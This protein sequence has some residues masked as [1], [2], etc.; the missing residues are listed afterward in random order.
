MN[1]DAPDISTAR[2]NLACLEALSLPDQGL[3]L[4]KRLTLRFPWGK[5][6]TLDSLRPFPFSLYDPDPNELVPGLP[7]NECQRAI[8]ILLDKPWDEIMRKGYVTKASRQP[9]WYQLRYVISAEGWAVANSLEFR[10]EITAKDWTIEL[11]DD[12]RDT[13]W[14]RNFMRQAD[15]YRK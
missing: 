3:F 13:E 11:D 5:I 6:F 8:Q 9:Y 2:S 14:Y 1:S 10:N 12:E 4:L 7:S 15:K